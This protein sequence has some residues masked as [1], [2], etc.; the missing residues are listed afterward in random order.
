MA[1]LPR[2]ASPSAKDPKGR[3]DE[4][5]TT[6][7]AAS[8]GGRAAARRDPDPAPGRSAPP[9]LELAGVVKR[10]GA[11]EVVHGV[12]LV[13]EEGEM[14]TLLGPSGSGKTTILKLVAGFTDIS[15][16]TI[17]LKGRDVSTVSPAERAIGMVFQN[18][19]LFPHMSVAENIAYGLKMQ[20]TPREERAA[21]VTEML[22]LVGLPGTQD[23]L[24]RELS[25][26]QQQRVALARALAFR[27]SLLLMDEPL[28][29]L[30]QQLRAR[31]MVELRRIHREVGVTALYV[32]HDREEALTLSDRIGIMRDGILEGVGTPAELL[33]RPSTRFIATFFG[34]HVLLPARILGTGGK[35]GSA[36]VQCLGQ[37]VEVQG[38][39]AGIEPGAEAALA[40]PPAA[41]SAGRE[42]PSSIGIDVTVLEHLD[43]GD[44]LR[45]TCEVMVPGGGESAALIR[46]SGERL[47]ELSGKLAPGQLVRL[48]ADMT[49]VALLA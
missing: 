38:A 15:A 9:A 23:R 20:K 18:Y 40:V 36:L 1:S 28:G 10:Y 29:A 44:R 26:G 32:T 30:D 43:L 37:R 7:Q 45:V 16:G 25:G 46:L 3:R 48:Y 11:S 17:Y 2:I 13:V 4:Y 12:D 27:P 35:P 24:P 21:R 39:P 42:A 31:M 22:E 19:A 14:L 8:E 33:T 5:M 49:L 41:V 34:G 6:G 47:G